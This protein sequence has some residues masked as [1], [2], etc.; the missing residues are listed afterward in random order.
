MK[1]V[2]KWFAIIF[3]GLGFLT[4]IIGSLSQK[5][6]GQPPLPA[7]TTQAN[8]PPVVAAGSTTQMLP[9]ATPGDNVYTTTAQKL[10]RDY[11]DNEVA[12]DEKMKGK[13][14][15]VSGTVQSIDKSITDSIIIA[16]RTGNEF[17]AAHMNMDDSE[18]D[19]AIALKRG[20]KVT[21]RCE[22]MMRSMGSPF[23]SDC[24][25]RMN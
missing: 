22:R 5:P 6:Q 23:G 7:G 16:L 25:F 24:K 1:K 14:I 13:V 19:K 18:K 8:P 12:A 15:E 3:F 20:A 4:L 2:L 9:A 21:I 11:H 17:M 10:A